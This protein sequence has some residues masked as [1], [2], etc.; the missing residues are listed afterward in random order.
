MQKAKEEFPCQSLESCSGE[1]GCY[2]MENKTHGFQFESA[3]TKLTCP[4]YSVGNDQD[5]VQ[6]FSMTAWV[7]KN[8]A[9]VKNVKRC[10]PVLNMCAVAYFGS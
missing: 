3:F 8:G 2:N 6:K 10:Q 7:N 5:E 4:N 9:T 1:W